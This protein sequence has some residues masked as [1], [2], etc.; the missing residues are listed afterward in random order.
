MPSG[1]NTVS[2]DRSSAVDA[3]AGEAASV[4]ARISFSLPQIV[5]TLARLDRVRLVSQIWPKGADEGEGL[6]TA[7]VAS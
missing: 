3:V 1:R 2:S 7:A 5:L 4:Y 6:T